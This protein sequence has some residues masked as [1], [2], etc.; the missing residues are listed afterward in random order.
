MI[1]G[2]EVSVSPEILF[3]M[4]IL[5]LNSRPTESETFESGAQHFWF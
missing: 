4:Q 3:E 5:R 2:P 1:S